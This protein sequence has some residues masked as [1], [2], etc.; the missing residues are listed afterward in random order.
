MKTKE[1]AK[2]L[3]L[4]AFETGLAITQAI[5]EIVKNGGEYGRSD[6]ETY[7]LIMTAGIELPLYRMCRDIAIEAGKVIKIGQLLKAA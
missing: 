1:D 3:V 7:A 4:G 2:K 5:I 6:G